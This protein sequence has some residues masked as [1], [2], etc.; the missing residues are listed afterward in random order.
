MHQFIK[1]PNG[2]YGKV[3]ALSRKLLLFK[4]IMSKYVATETKEACPQEFHWGSEF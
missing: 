2:S 4:R 3:K 1:S